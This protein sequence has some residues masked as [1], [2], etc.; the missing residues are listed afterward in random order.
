MLER[1][2]KKKKNVLRALLQAGKPTLGTHV[3][4]IWPGIAEITG[5]GKGLQ[6][7]LEEIIPDQCSPSV[8]GIHIQRKTRVVSPQKT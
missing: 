1:K 8:M 4:V 3:H 7:S 5:A 2:F 6:G